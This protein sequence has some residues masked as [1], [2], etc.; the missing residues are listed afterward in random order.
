[1]SQALGLHK[2]PGK[3]LYFVNSTKTYDGCLTSGSH[4]IHH[5]LLTTMQE[6]KGER[7]KREML[8][9]GEIERS[10]FPI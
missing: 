2:D 10:V 1:M 8:L 4:L 6:A 3:S 9:E 7:Q 5:K